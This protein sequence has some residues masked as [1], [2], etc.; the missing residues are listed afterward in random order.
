MFVLHVGGE[1]WAIYCV[2]FISCACNHSK[3]VVSG[4]G[5]HVLMCNIHYVKKLANYVGI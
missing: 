1:A 3:G 5:V 4:L 2:A